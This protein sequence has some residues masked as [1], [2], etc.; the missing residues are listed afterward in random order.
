MNRLRP[1]ASIMALTLLLP[2]ASAV[3]ALIPLDA[4]TVL[5]PSVTTTFADPC[6]A[7]PLDVD[8][9]DDDDDDGGSCEGCSD[10]ITGGGSA[11]L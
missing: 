4:F 1:L 2:A 3:A 5:D 9:A 11:G 7:V 8:G 10:S 6:R